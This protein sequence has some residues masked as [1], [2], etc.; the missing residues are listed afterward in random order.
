MNMPKVSVI[1]PVYN[2]VRFVAKA[3]ES[4]LAQDFRDWELIVVNDGS[5]DGTADVLAG[6]TDDRI[7]VFHQANG[8]EAVARNRG[9][10]AVS[11]EYVAFLDADDLYLPN[12]LGDMSAYL[13]A[14]PEAHALFSDGYFCDENDRPLGRLSEVRP[15]PFTGN[16]LEPLVLDPA[17][18]AGIICTMTRRATISD[19][20]VRFDPALVIGP[21]W[22]FWIH[23]AR[24]AQFGYLDHLTCMYR[25]HQTNITLT[26]GAKR[27]KAD[28]VRG[29]LKVMTSD[30]F[31]A[32]SIGTRRKFFYN[33]LVALLGNDPGQQQTIME[34][35]AFQT[36]PVDLRADLLRLVASNHL[37]KRREN[38]FAIDCL[39]Q[40]LQLQ[41]N[42]QKSRVL[43]RLADTNPA[44]AAAIL[45]AWKV[46][47]RAQARVRTLGQ[48]RTKPVPAAL[49]PASE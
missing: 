15:G 10:D 4:L 16:I 19:S 27:R 25:V 35:P 21:D 44:L 31:E 39:R 22:D 23:L 37:T 48:R 32:L 36:L 9:L 49:M 26:S 20:G 28:L 11:A 43:L 6:F 17:V 12:A 18:I 33:L 13:D 41:P 5:T 40:S 45:S 30:W 24:Y 8:G 46:G 42:N 34:A 1:M 38:K 2:G 29:R 47:H 3:I 7:H 14:H